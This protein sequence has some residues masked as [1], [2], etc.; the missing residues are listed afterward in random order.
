[1][2][3]VIAT[4]ADTVFGPIYRTN[5]ARFGTSGH[6]RAVNVFLIQ[7]AERRTLS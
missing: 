7:K 1:V 4:A 6:I 5:D 3:T 2:I